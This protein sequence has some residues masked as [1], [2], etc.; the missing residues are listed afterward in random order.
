MKRQF[1]RLVLVFLTLVVLLTMAS[2]R[3]VAGKIPFW[4][5]FE[6]L[7][8]IPST[9]ETEEQSTPAE[10]PA[11]TTPEQTPPEQTTPGE[12]AHTWVDATCTAPKTCSI[13]SATEGEAL[14]HEAG[15][16]ATCTAAQICTRCDYVFVAALGHDEESHEAKAA[17]CTAIGWDAYVTCSRCG[18]HG[19]DP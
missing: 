18:R 10:T 17:T 14:G 11:D 1:K 5:A 2:C 4:K 12:C 3:N 7:D 8:L 16:E 15:D 13:C 6:N 19:F 9:S